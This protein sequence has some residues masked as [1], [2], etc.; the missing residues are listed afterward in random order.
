YATEITLEFQPRVS[1]YTVTWPSIHWV[2]GGSAPQP[3]QVAGEY[4]IIK[5]V[6]TQEAGDLFGALWFGYRTASSAAAA[7][8]DAQARS[9]VINS[10]YL[11]D[12]STIAMNVVAGTSATPSIIAGSVTNAMLAGSI[13]PS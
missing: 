1:T 13:Q 6:R 4:T 10:T 2:D 12:S 7:Y 11:I 3:S 9:A 8:T 5:L